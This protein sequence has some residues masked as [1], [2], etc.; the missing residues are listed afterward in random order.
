MSRRLL[1]AVASLAL[2]APLALAEEAPFRLRHSL[3]L[4]APRLE[5]TQIFARL[6][7]NA[8]TF[9]TA[10]GVNAPMVGMELVVARRTADGEVVMAC[11]DNAETAQRFLEAPAESVG[12]R[13]A[14]NQ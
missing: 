8:R 13:K 12:R 6:A 1:V 10:D 4:M 11:T 9:E 3:A 5:V 2:A 7:R 14:L